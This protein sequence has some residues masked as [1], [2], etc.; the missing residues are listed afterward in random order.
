MWFVESKIFKFWEVSKLSIQFLT[1]CKG[2]S[3]N[4]GALWSLRTKDPTFSTSVQTQLWRSSKLVFLKSIFSSNSYIFEFFQFKK[5]HVVKIFD[6][7]LLSCRI[8]YF[9]TMR[10][11]KAGRKRKVSSP[12]SNVVLNVIFESKCFYEIRHV[13]TFFT[14]IRWHIVNLIFRNLTRCKTLDLKSCFSRNHEKC[15]TCRYLAVN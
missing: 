10:F 8:F 12:R 13:S 5:R 1:L 4:F 6:E 14:F 7:N 11:E 2:F 3:S 15:I 9:K